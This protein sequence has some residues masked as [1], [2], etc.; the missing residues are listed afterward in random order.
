MDHTAGTTE[1]KQIITYLILITFTITIDMARAAAITSDHLHR[2]LGCGTADDNTCGKGCSIP[3]VMLVNNRY[4]HVASLQLLLRI[5][6]KS[7]VSAIECLFVVSVHLR[8]GTCIY[9]YSLS[10]SSKDSTPHRPTQ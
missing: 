2:R 3:S 8:W 1:N 9:L 5:V 4:D 10:Q 7:R 6:M